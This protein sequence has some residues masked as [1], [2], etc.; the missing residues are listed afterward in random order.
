MPNIALTEARACAASMLAALK[1]HTDTP[2]QVQNT[3]FEDIAE[4]VFRRH[5]RV[6]KPGT[7]T[8]ENE[9]QSPL[10]HL[11]R[12]PLGHQ[13]VDDLQDQPSGPSRPLAL[14]HAPAPRETPF[15]APMRGRREV[16]T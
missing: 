13:S 10:Q 15:E 14:V 9:I 11:L 5:A 3:R 6:W 2:P 12:N 1:R 7:L 16:R 4:A 8:M